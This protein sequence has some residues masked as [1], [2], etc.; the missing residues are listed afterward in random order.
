MK[1]AVFFVSDSTGI[2]AENLGRSLLIQFP[3]FEFDQLTIPYVTS[4]VKANTIA[5]QINSAS[6]TN[7][8]KSLVFSTL[9]DPAIRNIIAT[10][11][12]FFIDTFELLVSSL[13]QELHGKHTQKIGK[14]HTISNTK[15]YD[16]RVAAI[17]FALTTDDGIGTNHYDKTEIIL[18]GVSRSGKTPTCLYLAL[19]F[20][21]FAANYP[22]ADAELL[23]VD[24]PSVLRK[25]SN[26]LFGL[27]INAKRLHEI[28]TERKPGS[29]YATLKQC[30]TEL[31]NINKIFI[32]NKI[33]YL[34]SSTFSIEE[35]ATKII[36][37][38]NLTR[39]L[40]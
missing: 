16:A 20:G 36:A 37:T 11:N 34:D 10:S 40:I 27:T 24:L 22:I 19:K 29:T 31:K 4:T 2:T 17:E 21:I 32:Q 23:T 8:T 1:R 3:Q 33:P 25:Y 13:E 5:T 30:Q 39:R 28:R 9:A 12:C 15:A 35:I 6:T 38:K 26:K 18:I 14:L 7:Q